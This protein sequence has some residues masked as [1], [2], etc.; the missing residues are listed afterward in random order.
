LQ[1]VWIP[2]PVPAWE[3]ITVTPV[4]EDLTPSW[5]LKAPGIHMVLTCV[6][7]GKHPY[8]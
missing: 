3:L 6:H 2:F 7:I 8:N 1:R 4:P 5:L